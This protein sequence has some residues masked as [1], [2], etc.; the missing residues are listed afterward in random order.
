MTLFVRWLRLP[1]QQ[2]TLGLEA[3]GWLSLARLLVHHV[4]KAPLTP[5]SGDGPRRW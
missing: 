5:A 4:P 1:P 2:R 3:V